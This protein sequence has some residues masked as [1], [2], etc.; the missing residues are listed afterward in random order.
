MLAGDFELTLVLANSPEVFE[1]I[2]S[3]GGRIDTGSGYYHSFLYRGMFYFYL[4]DFNMGIFMD[5]TSE[6][7]GD[8]V[9]LLILFV[10]PYHTSIERNEYVNGIPH[11]VLERHTFGHDVFA[12]TMG[13]NTNG[14]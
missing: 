13:N 14:Y 4:S 9:I 5:N 11:G 6:G 3:Y 2:G 12:V 1:I 8:V 10:Y 7:A